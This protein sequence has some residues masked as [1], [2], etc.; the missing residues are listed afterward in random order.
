MAESSEKT[1]PAWVLAACSEDDYHDLN[2]AHS[3]QFQS[4]TWTAGT[5]GHIMALVKAD[6]GLPPSTMNWAKVLQ[7]PAVPP[8]DLDM[9]ALREFAACGPIGQVC[10]GCKGMRKVPCHACHGQGHAE[11]ECSCGDLHD[12]ECETCHGTK[13][14]ACVLCS[15]DQF[16]SK[17]RA[18]LFNGIFNKALLRRVL[19]DF[20]VTDERFARATWRQ[21][22]PRTA[23]WIEAVDGSW[24]IGIMPLDPDTA[25]LPHDAPVFPSSAVT[26]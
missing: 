3:V 8:L 6:L 15:P 2:R 10:A 1:I 4:E 18:R 25:L 21:A 13:H 24:I 14:V 22:G 20:P 11:H 12:A 19:H 5:N 9:G 7:A 23:G 17:E 16:G 26:A